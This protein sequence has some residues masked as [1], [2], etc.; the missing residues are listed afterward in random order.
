MDESLASAL[1]KQEERERAELT[2]SDYAAA[3]VDAPDWVEEPIPSLDTWRRWQAAQDKA[4]AYKRAQA[5]A[6]KSTL[7][8]D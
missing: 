6:R 1:I 2:Q 5:R 7:A 4:L 3:G 8:T